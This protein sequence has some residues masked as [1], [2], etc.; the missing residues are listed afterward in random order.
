M[1]E[2][3]DTVKHEA[4]LNKYVEAR[5]K[6]TSATRNAKYKYEQNIAEN[7]KEDTKILLEVCPMEI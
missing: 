5:N 2:V 1:K 6:A 7:I 3:H 4:N